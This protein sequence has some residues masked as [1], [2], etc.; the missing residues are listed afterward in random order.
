MSPHLCRIESISSHIASSIL[1]NTKANTTST[2]EPNTST[3]GEEV[4]KK[5]I[6]DHHLPS[7]FTFHSPS[8]LTLTLS[9]PPKLKGTL[10][11]PIPLFSLTFTPAH[12]YSLYS[13]VPPFLQS[14][15]T[16]K[17]R[18]N[19]N[20]RTIC[21]TT[22]SAFQECRFFCKQLRHNFKETKET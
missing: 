1:S 10:P 12:L 18:R 15:H 6:L 3:T 8:L 9:L 5:G 19:R 20:R 17:G 11:P 21:Q 7:P 4:K 13:L 2:L 16:Q 14:I 22:R